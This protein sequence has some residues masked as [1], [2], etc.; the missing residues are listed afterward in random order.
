M[1]VSKLFSRVILICL[2]LGLFCVAGCGDKKDAK[3]DKD[4]KSDKSS[5]KTVAGVASKEALLKQVQ[6]AMEKKDVAAIMALGYW[7]E[8]VGDR[9]FSKQG[10]EKELE[11]AKGF[12]KRSYKFVD[13]HETELGWKWTAE[14][15]C[16]IMIEGGKPSEYCALAVGKKDG[17]FFLIAKLGENGGGPKPTSQEVPEKAA[18]PV[19]K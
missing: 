19:K 10:F 18:A 12:S 1:N 2:L 14:P 5:K 4:E 8:T 9:P 17:K 6:E 11:A 16:G 15:V 7:E 3:Q 13:F